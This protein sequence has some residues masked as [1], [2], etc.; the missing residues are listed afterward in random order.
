MKRFAR[1][2][3]TGMYAPDKVMTNADFI[4]LLG[5]D[6]DEFVGVLK[7]RFAANGIEL[8]LSKLSDCVYQL[9]KRKVHLSVQGGG[10]NAGGSLV[11]RLG[12]GWQSFYEFLDRARF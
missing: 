3:G 6:V 12:G 8:P 5:E 11:V 9:G 7:K 2:I 4:P 1:I 10:V